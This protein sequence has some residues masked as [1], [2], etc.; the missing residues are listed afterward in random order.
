MKRIFK[1]CLLFLV[2]GLL[3]VAMAPVKEPVFLQLMDANGKLVKGT[4]VARGYE[5]Q[6]EVLQFSGVSSGN[7]ELRFSMPSSGASSILSA[8][9]GEKGGF[10]WAVFS[11]TTQGSD[12]LLLR[13]TIRLE[14]ITVVRT[15]ENIG[16][17][18]VTLKADRIGT[19]HYEWNRKSGVLTVAGKT[20]YDYKAG[21]S[22]N[23]F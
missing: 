2:T 5:R 10:S 12:K 9:A 8:A 1:F 22:W 15:Q 20:G 6:I 13:S 7:P 3:L 23:S 18:E 17:T 4:S 21:T 19:T 14:G 16:S 11:T